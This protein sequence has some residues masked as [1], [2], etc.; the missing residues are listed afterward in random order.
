ME[1]K[2]SKDDVDHVCDPC[3]MNSTDFNPDIYMIK[4]LKESR[5]SELMDT[6]Q[7]LYKQ[8]QTLDSE[9]Q[10][11]IYENY[12]KFISATETV[13]KMTSHFDKM[14][15]ELN[16]LSTNMD[17]I[18]SRSN[19][20][21]KNLNGKREQLT[22][23]SAK[24]TL[25]EKI[26]FI[27]ELPNKMKQLIDRNEYNKAVDDYLNAKYS[28]DK[29]AHLSSFRNIQTDCNEMLAEIRRHFYEQLADENLTT[30]QL[31]D[32]I[33]YLAKLN[34]CPSNLC[35]KYFEMCE[36]KMNTSLNE[37]KLQTKSDGPDR[38][39]ILEFIDNVCNNYIGT[40]NECIQF[41]SD[42]FV[43]GHKNL[44][45]QT[46]NEDMESR[47][48][49]FVDQ[50][51]EDLFDII[52]EQIRNEQKIPNNII[53]FV[54]ALDRFYRRIQMLN[55]IVGFSDFSRKSL[56]IIYQSTKDQC[57]HLLNDLLTK[58]YE[59]L[60]NVRHDIVQ[61]MTKTTNI[62]I[63]RSTNNKHDDHQNQNTLSETVIAFETSICENLKTVLSN[64][65]PFLYR[66]LTFITK[67]FKDKFIKDCIFETIIIKYIEYILTIVEEFEQSYTTS[68]ISSCFILILS[69]IC[70]D[71]SDSIISY[72]I[73]YTEEIFAA[74]KFGQRYAIPLTKRARDDGEKLLN[75]Y[76]CIEGQSI[77][78]MIRKSVETRDWMSTVEPRSVRSVMKRIIED[79]TLIDFLVGQL[80]EEGQRIER[81]SDSSRTFST[82]S[83]NKTCYSKSNWSYGSSSFDNNIISN[84]QKLFNDKIE[85]FGK[86]EFSKLSVATG[87][88]KIGL[89]TLI[90]CVR[91]CTFSRYGFQQ[92]QVDSYYIQTRLWRFASDEKII[93]NLI[94]EV[95]TSSKKR[96][97]DPIGMERSVIENICENR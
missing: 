12:N 30:I 19:D 96:C 21:A 3:N 40:L 87:I 29:F 2:S 10:T 88:I 85:I 77:S 41:Y 80:Y 23:M 27:L 66:E 54:R 58:F 25:L 62:S 79:I 78:H 16:L 84:I 92:I 91:L 65:N 5:L 86:V 50:R 22:Q 97:L 44:A 61:D 56:D 26:Q 4:I 93:V 28:L 31:N 34:E 33:S 73:K 63:L 82:F 32:S 70:R 15:H 71:L 35:G 94:D 17:K 83:V 11:L 14:E 74:P 48:K 47:L 43:V 24:N 37:I 18:T 69:K 64:L 20:I 68:H 38:P 9:M 52:V 81:S 51:M 55:N 1:S 45:I 39:D 75:A 46:I 36:K 72:L 59:E 42:C 60:S 53:M 57:D 95:I 89:K 67:D 49:I 76:V 90:E 6:E 13:K 7:M 8:I